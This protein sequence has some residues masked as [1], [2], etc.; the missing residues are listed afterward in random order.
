MSLTTLDLATLQQA[1]ACDRQFRG[2]CPS[3]VTISFGV[4]VLNDRSIR[5]D[6]VNGKAA[7]TTHSDAETPPRFALVATADVWNKFFQA[8]PEPGYQSFLGKSS[9]AIS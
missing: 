5:V 4:C 2:L 7:V 1:L 8:V 9:R 6:I 3:T